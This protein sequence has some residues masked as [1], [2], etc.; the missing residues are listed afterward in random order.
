[1]VKNLPSNAGD[2]GLIPGQGTKIPHAVGQLR[3]RTATTEPKCSGARAPQLEKPAR[4]N[5]RS[6]ISQ[7]RSHVPQLRPEAAK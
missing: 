1:M 5:G 2:P 7:R 6:R 4:H 3:P